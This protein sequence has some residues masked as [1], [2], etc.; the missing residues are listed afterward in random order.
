MKPNDRGTIKWTSL[1]MPEHIEMLK[2]VWK[3][4]EKEE[5]AILDEQQIVENSFALHCAM[6]D[7]L[8]VNI[9]HHNGVNYSYTTVKVMTMTPD[10]NEIH[11]KDHK[12][13]EGI[14]ILFDDIYEVTVL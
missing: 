8:P 13:K 3:E 7:G 14:T 1:M 5:K 6:E 12:D 9:K 2:E 11:C 10:T 4:D